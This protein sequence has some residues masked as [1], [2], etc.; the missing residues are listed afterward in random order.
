MLNE[1]LP[2]LAGG[3][4]IGAAATLLLLLN[5][6]IAGISGIAWGAISGQ[7]D[8]AW[9]WLFLVGLVLGPVLYHFVSGSTAPAPSA[10]PEPLLDPPG[11]WSILCGLRAGD[12]S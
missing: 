3:F 10:A 7:A 12:G 9:R 11:V 8:N 5:G 6:R 2:A 1:Y 4:A